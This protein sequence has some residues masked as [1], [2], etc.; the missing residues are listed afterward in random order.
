MGMGKVSESHDERSELAHL[1]EKARRKKQ[2]RAD[3]D[4]CQTHS[5]KHSLERL[6]VHGGTSIFETLHPLL[7]AFVSL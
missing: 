5:P 2:P 4:I 6:I 7:L 3:I 1:A